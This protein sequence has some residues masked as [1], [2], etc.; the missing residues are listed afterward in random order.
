MA[1]KTATAANGMSNIQLIWFWAWKWWLTET[2]RLILLI[3]LPKIHTHTHAH[4]RYI[5]GRNAAAGWTRCRCRCLCWVG[6]LDYLLVI[7][8][9]SIPLESYYPKSSGSSSKSTNE[10]R[11]HTQT[12][13][14]ISSCK[15]I[16]PLNG[17]LW[18]CISNSASVGVL[19]LFNYYYLFE[20]VNVFR[21]SI[22][23]FICS[24]VCLRMSVVHVH[25]YIIIIC[26]LCEHLYE[27]E[28]ACACK[29]TGDKINCSI[30]ALNI[31]DSF[32][33]TY[34]SACINY[35]FC[36]V[37]PPFRAVLGKN[38]FVQNSR[39]VFQTIFYIS[40][41]CYVL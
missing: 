5:F 29:H 37:L 34:A 40:F 9:S 21:Y 26:I 20:G 24:C 41:I 17:S 25:M 3:N 36:M 28:C 30:V 31:F 8:G 27:S 6:C 39:L 1:T 19:L 18:I 16:I 13:K 23:V 2:K 10:D 11:T 32:F 15:I 7:G 33:C 35:I 12:N 4:Y 38:H 14:H 22:F